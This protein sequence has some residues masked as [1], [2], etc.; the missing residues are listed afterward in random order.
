MVQLRW[1]ISKPRGIRTDAKLF[2]ALGCPRRPPE[3]QG[4]GGT[5]WGGQVRFEGGE[6]LPCRNLGV[7]AGAAHA[8]GPAGLRAQGSLGRVGGVHTPMG[9]ARVLLGWEDGAPPRRR[10]GAALRRR[11]PGVHE[12]VGAWRFPRAAK[13]PPC[14]ND[15][16]LVP[17]RVPSLPL[18]RG[19]AAARTPSS[20]TS[21]AS[22]STPPHR[23]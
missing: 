8:R 13:P 11:R 17:G 19:A 16:Q 15:G 20:G 9:P 21:W 14:T 10:P 23:P 22:G 2:W 1:Q 3:P 7:S 5:S 6:I 12:A 4:T 18:P